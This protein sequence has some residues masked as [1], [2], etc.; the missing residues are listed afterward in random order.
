MLKYLR[1][2]FLVCSQERKPTFWLFSV[3]IQKNIKPSLICERK[4]LSNPTAMLLCIYILVYMSHA[5][6]LSFV[7]NVVCFFFFH[8]PC[9][10]DARQEIR[11]TTT[12][13]VVICQLCERTEEIGYGNR[14]RWTT[15]HPQAWKSHDNLTLTSRHLILHPLYLE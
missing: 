6:F 3:Y 2:V 1:F 12:S 8:P 14:L 5:K 4:C 15:W 13:D 9:F 11:I 7:S 10:Q